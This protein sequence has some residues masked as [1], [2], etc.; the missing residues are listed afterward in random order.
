M[1]LHLWLPE[2]HVEA[3][4]IGSVILAAILLKLGGFGMLR[5]IV[6]ISHDLALNMRIIPMLFCIISVFYAS[7]LAFRHFDLKKIIAYS[8]ILHMN[9]SALAFSTESKIALVG[10]IISMLCHSVVSS[11]LFFTAGFLYEKFKTR[12]LIYY[13]SLLQQSSYLY[14]F[15]FF[16]PPS[17]MAVPF[18]IA[19]TGESLLLCGLFQSSLIVFYLTIFSLFFSGLFSFT[20]MYR[21]LYSNTISNYKI[22][23]YSLVNQVYISSFST[24]NTLSF[25]ITETVILSLL[26]SVNVLFFFFRE[27]FIENVYNFIALL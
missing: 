27:L 25:S 7:F 16:S 11:A 2:A 18:S 9:L 4:T 1:P 21:L 20:S 23:Q 26:L 24:N 19:F 5:V 14:T 3:P 10:A 13:S 17:N 12:N 8:S 6:P 15:F 22:I